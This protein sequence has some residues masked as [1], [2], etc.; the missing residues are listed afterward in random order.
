MTR[1][2]VFGGGLPDEGL[3]PDL[4]PLLTDILREE[5]ES[6]SYGGVWGYEP[7]RALIARRLG[8]RAGVHLDVDNIVLTNGSSGAIELAAGVLVQ[9]DTVV[10]VEELTYL[11]AVAIFRKCGAR[12]VTVPVD[13]DGMDMVAL[14]KMLE[15]TPPPDRPSVIYTIATCQSPTG[16]IMPPDRRATL[17]ALA[18]TYDLTIIQDDT[19]GEFRFTD[20]PA[21]PLLGTSHD[22]V[23][24]VGSFSKTLA[25]GLRLGWLAAPADRCQ[26]AVARRTDLG[27]APPM[28]RV[29]AR[30]ISDG[31]FDSHVE[32]MTR[33]YE[34]KRDRVLEALDRNGPDGAEW[35]TP[36][37]GFFVWLTLRD[38]DLEDL[39]PV[40]ARE[41][42]EYLDSTHFNPGDSYPAGVRLAYGQFP[43]ESLM[44][45]ISRLGRAI[46]RA[47]RRS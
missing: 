25:P 33:V 35:S 37:G 3:R 21:R 24:H 22:H 28:Q 38:I 14:A 6:L 45:G 32:A 26:A 40:A 36:R 44:E 12:I 29:V 1:P 2:I 17:G 5:P 39:R 10:A 18:T 47:P 4:G 31:R 30:F 16:T 19:Y 41:G 43:T 9:Q 46:T 20:D 7:L 27:N 42:V 11:G 13:R 15:N 23:M 34:Q 8:T